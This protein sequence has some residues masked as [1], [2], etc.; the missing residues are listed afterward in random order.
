M[1]NCSF[2]GRITQDI[3]LKNTP[4]GVAVCSFNIAVDRPRSKEK[5]TDFFTV[6]AW[7]NTAEFIC[8]YFRKGQKIAL[9][10]MLTTR[11]WEDQN[12][13][14]RISYEIVADNAEFCEKSENGTA[15]APTNSP[16]YNQNPA[17][18]D[19]GDFMDID[20]EEDLPF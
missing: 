11:K 16:S 9:T 18:N 13:N 2:M 3:E 19:T 8:K 17:S 14:K 12:G 7:R 10:G 1:N 6:V 20:E 4:N 5:V 15:T